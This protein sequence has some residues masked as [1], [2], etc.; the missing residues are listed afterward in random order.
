MVSGKPSLGPDR[1]V[2]G[3]V[4]LLGWLEHHLDVVAVGIIDVNG[5]EAEV[6]HDID[7]VADLVGPE[8]SEEVGETCATE[9]EMLDPHPI[10]GAAG[11]A[12]DEMH[13]R[14]VTAIVPRSRAR[15]ARACALREA[16]YVRVKARHAFDIVGQD[17]DVVE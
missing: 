3:N 4:R 2:S 14:R 8:T 12:V 11:R 10:D 15:K 5:F 6:R 7:L 9:S 16:E 1:L 13:H 17:V